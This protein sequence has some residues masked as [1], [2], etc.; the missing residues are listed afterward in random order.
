M[1][2]RLSPF[3]PVARL[4][5]AGLLIV[6]GVLSAPLSAKDKNKAL[7]PEDIL[8]ARTVRVVVDPDAGEPLDQPGA[9]STARDNV[10]KALLEWGRLQPMMDGNETD[11]VIVVRTGSGR[12]GRPTVKGGPVDQRPGVGQET[13]SSIRVG[14]Q[15]GQAPPV[16]N[17]NTRPQ[18]RGPR[19]SNEVGS[20]DDS[21]AVYRGK[22]QYPLDSPAVWRYVAKDCLQPPTVKAVEEFRKALAEAD[23]AAQQ[24]KK[25]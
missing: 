21:F 6:A 4:P 15:W 13:D 9:N 3:L 25:P 23:K 16:S 11:L 20:P 5:L 10:E 12:L 18:D 22:E 8:R 1:N 14:G 2:F 24:S 17:P 7:L 19:V